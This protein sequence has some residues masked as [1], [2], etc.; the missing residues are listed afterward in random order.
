[1]LKHLTF[2][3]VI[4]MP[5]ILS[6]QA[7]STADL[8]QMTVEGKAYTLHKVKSGET[9]YSICKTYK[10]EL[11][12]L[13][14]INKIGSSGYTLTVGDLL[15]I[16][17]YAEK[18]APVAVDEKMIAEN[19]YITHVVKQGETLY[20]ISRSYNGVTPAMI[21]EKNS[22]S[23]DTVRINQK[24]IIP[25]QL[26]LVAIYKATPATAKKA[27]EQPA[28]RRTKETLQKQFA[29]EEAAKGGTEITRGIATWLDNDDNENIS[30]M[31]A[32]HKYAPIGT[33]VR[34]RN[35]MNNRELYVKVIGKLPDSEENQSVV[36]K[37]SK[38]A[39]KQLHVLDEKF[40]VELM[41]PQQG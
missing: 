23:S 32:L 6:A 29:K 28:D 34:V 3:A 24:L 20:S 4:F 21:K 9:L 14:T 10:V 2:L 11:A 22:M 5:A 1:M 31:I 41:I 39:A 27:E 38:A 30:N 26:N 33:I 25:Q 18:A 36:I 12:E 16:P 37:M 19:G 17:L 13:V 8:S 35:L 15:I 40:L 7:T